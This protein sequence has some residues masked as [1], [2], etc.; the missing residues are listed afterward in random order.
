MK[1][2]YELT[3]EQSQK[4]VMTPELIQAIQILQFNTQELESYVEEQLLTNP[5]LEIQTP[6]QSE[7]GESDG[8]PVKKTEE[9]D[10]REGN[11]FETRENNE[12]DWAE[13]FK[14]R[15]YD[16][17]SYKQWEYNNEPQENTYEQFVSSEITLS[18]H[19]MFQLQF[20]PI[21]KN[22]RQIGRYMIESL[23]ENGY[24]TLTP[25]EIAQEMDTSLENVQKVLEAVQSF[26][27]A[28]VGARS[29]QECLLIQLRHKGNED[30]ILVEVINHH[31]EDVAGNRLN[32]I[33]KTLNVSTK[34]IQEISDIIKSLEP[35]PGR[36]FGS[37]SET[38]YIIPDV[39][40][41]KVDGEYIVSVNEQSA[42]RLN[43]SRYYQRMLI[44]SDKESHLSKFLTSRLNSALWLIKS[45]EQRRQTIYNVVNAVVKYQIDFFEEGPKYLK[46]LTLKQIADEVGIHESTV[47]RSINGKYMQSPRGV[48]E[49]KYF[50]T[51]GVSGVGGEGIASESIKTFIKEI[52]D[53]ENE[54]EPYS[55]Q[56]MVEMLAKKGIDISR[57]TVAKYRDEMNVPSSSKRKR[58]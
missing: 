32:N 19:L 41:E 37:S 39:T 54:K 22:C 52:V 11:D 7:I 57:R 17:I 47:S 40:V 42:P 2:G 1:L 25:E 27:P 13:H 12:F 18:E 48:F 14:E 35:K 36:Q 49:I 5:V 50:F 3:I 58:Y 51:S 34:K 10:S 24:M 55:D 38:R 9:F 43:V 28:G 6:A 45:I 44:E 30:P 56:A 4:L 15:E 8:E 29:L 31:L 53:S 33:A 23:D 16:D 46:T 26:E 21:K 20:A